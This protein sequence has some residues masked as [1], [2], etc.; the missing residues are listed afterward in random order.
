MPGSAKPPPPKKKMCVFTVI[1]P[2]LFFHPYP[3]DLIY[4]EYGT[5]NIT[6][7]LFIGKFCDFSK[8][9]SLSRVL[10]NIFAQDN[11]IQSSWKDV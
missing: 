11:N 8:I 7:A 5:N 3:F 2:T 4:S 10:T 6:L 9:L 1:R